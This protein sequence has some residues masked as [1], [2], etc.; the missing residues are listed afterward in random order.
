MEEQRERGEGPMVRPGAGASAR[1]AIAPAFKRFRQTTTGVRQMAAYC[2]QLATLIE[3]GIPLL[4][5]LQVLSLR[6]ND[7]RMRRVSADLARQVEEGQMLSTAMMRHPRVFS[8]S[9]VGVV[10]TGEAGGIL[11][12]SLRRL[13]GLLERRAE[14]RRR[15]VSA[16]IY[17]A[18]A[19][20]VEIVVI[21]LIVV[22]ALPKLIRA[23]PN[24]Q[25]LPDITR[26]LLGASD[27]AV[28]Y[29]LPLL[30]AVVGIVLLGV[31]MMRF[32]GTRMAVERAMLYIPGLGGLTRKMNV[33]KFSRT[34]GSL[35]AAGI[36]LVDALAI[37]AETSDNMVVEQT[38]NRVHSTVERGGKME[39]P[40]RSAPVFEPMVVDMIMVGDEAGALDT[41]LL[42]I[43]DSYDSEVDILLRSIAST[44]EPILIVLLGLAVAFVAVAVFLPYVHIVQ[45]PTL[46]NF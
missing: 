26:W 29:W 41:M 5:S 24:Q 21:V 31:I 46:M 13:A 11:E 38:L 14:L 37:S 10:R 35:T 33:A 4:R 15:V 7:E 44:I 2:R 39:E 12:D 17:P 23:Y 20:C 30:L 18:I 34:L 28:N 27:F 43:A 22:F 45:S 32:A 42:R 25:S 3:V 19:I 8:P 36:P 40:L 9:F 6:S 1:P 16:L